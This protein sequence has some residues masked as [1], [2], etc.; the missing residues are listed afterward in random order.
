[1]NNTL[2]IDSNI[3]G[4]R[5]KKIYGDKYASLLEDGFLDLDWYDHETNSPTK[6]SLEVLKFLLKLCKM[7]NISNIINVECEEDF[8]KSIYTVLNNIEQYIF[9]KIQ[10]FIEGVVSENELF[11][12]IKE[13]FIVYS[14]IHIILLVGVDETYR[15]AYLKN[16]Y[17]TEMLA[18]FKQHS[19]H[20]AIKLY[21]NDICD[22]DN[23]VDCQLLK[24]N[25]TLVMKN[26]A[27]Y[28]ENG[29]D[30]EHCKFKL[31][32]P[33]DKLDKDKIIILFSKLNNLQE[34]VKCR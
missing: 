9:N 19:W 25:I 14:K 4:L 28:Y 1:M 18:D 2:S 6:E 23:N 10:K 26:T 13:I 33:L 15:I 7:F 31:C 21:K 5:L 34:H 24:N 17:I 30:R 11:N 16:N 20:Y 29:Q 27:L 22:K 3:S 12:D 32:I 8:E